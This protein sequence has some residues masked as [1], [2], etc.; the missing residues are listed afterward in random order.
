MNPSGAF[1]IFLPSYLLVAA[2]AAGI[3]ELGHAFQQ[4]AVPDAARRSQPKRGNR[5]A[6]PTL[7]CVSTLSGGRPLYPVWGRARGV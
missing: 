4:A 3:F 1:L 7:F 2:L 5:V 6:F